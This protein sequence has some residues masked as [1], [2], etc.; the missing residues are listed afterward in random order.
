[1]PLHAQEQRIHDGSSSAHE[2]YGLGWA[3]EK[4]GL[5]E[6]PETVMSAPE[7]KFQRHFVH[8]RGFPRHPGSEFQA[9]GSEILKTC[10]VK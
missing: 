10:N 7:E 1:M 6:H 3:S 2:S 9:T 5:F 4:S 8:Q